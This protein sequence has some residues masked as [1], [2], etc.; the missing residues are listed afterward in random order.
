MFVHLTYILMFKN[1][2]TLQ[3]VFSTVHNP[4]LTTNSIQTKSHH[5]FKRESQNQKQMFLQKNRKKR[6]KCQKLI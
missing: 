5:Y 1:I 6:K 3:A 4:V 2:F